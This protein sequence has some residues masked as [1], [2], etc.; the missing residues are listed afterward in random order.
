MK[1][2]ILTIT[3]LLATPSCYGVVT[4][5]DRGIE[6]VGNAPLPNQLRTMRILEELV[7]DTYDVDLRGMR[8]NATVWWTDT[9][10]PKR[11]AVN[12]V[13]YRGNCYNGLMY[14]LDE[15]YV[16]QRREAP[17]KVCN[18]A[19]LTEYGHA[20]YMSLNGGRG[21]RLHLDRPFWALTEQANSKACLR[22]Y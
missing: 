22:G 12:A 9:P 18:T 5:G 13:V 14:T 3:L 4:P 11:T 6:V 17:T 20:I 10:C 7:E 16:A 21:D 15:M 1:H 2:L 8:Y 19:L